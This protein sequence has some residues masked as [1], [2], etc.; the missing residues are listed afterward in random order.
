MKRIGTTLFAF[1]LVFFLSACAS[2]P[3]PTTVTKVVHASP[4]KQR[5]STRTSE[6]TADNIPPSEAVEP[7][8][9]TDPNSEQPHDP[10][11]PYSQ[12]V[13]I[14]EP[15]IVEEVEE[16]EQEEITYDVPIIQNASVE[17]H[18]EYFQMR[19]KDRFEM[20]LSRSGRYI[21]LMKEIFKSYELPE[22]L[23]FVALIESGFN[24]AAYSRA[25]AVGPWQFIESTGRNYGLQ[26]NQWIDERRDPVKSTHA[27]AKYLKGLYNMFGS[28]PLALASYNA[29][30]GKV[31]RA[32][33][34]TRS[35]DFWDLRSTSHLQLETKNYVPKFMAA[36]IIAKNPEKYGFSPE[37]RE[38]LRFD[39]VVIK[40]PTDLRVIAQAVGVTYKELKELNPELR[41]TITPFDYINY[42]LMLP[43]GTKETYLEN[44]AKIPLE[45][46]IIQLRHRVRWGEALST[47]AR[48]YGTTIQA[49]RTLNHLGGRNTIR[50]GQYLLIP[51][52]SKATVNPERQRSS[53][54]TH[55]SVSKTN[56][57]TKM[58]RY[59]VRRGDTLSSLAKRYGTTVWAIRAMNSLGRSHVIRTGQYLRIPVTAAQHNLAANGL[60]K[61]RRGDT[62]SGIARRYGT[63]IH[64]IRQINNL[65]D[66]HI[67]RTG[68][69]LLI[70]I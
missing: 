3:K 59:K 9:L 36:T 62:L 24:P 47:L 41:S 44:I 8:T 11:D 34:R 52:G 63:T 69:R 40:H 15:L 25:K 55:V 17:G 45:E 16:P 50:A 1:A 57:D 64:A 23:V 22:D 53:P 42:T 58:L 12:M 7:T 56:P 32:I 21:P 33:R 6:I 51:M 30:E 18:I 10:H 14:P 26:I 38:P 31:M 43:Y 2:P 60:Y 68:Q 54:A 70:P 5:E 48:R 13:V 4:V 61:V 65:R 27:A 20:W 19:I 28:W 37:L 39:E 49:I 46:R 67:I 35:N 29:G 66:S